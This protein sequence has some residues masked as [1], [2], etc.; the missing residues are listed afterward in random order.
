MVGSDGVARVVDFGVSMAAGRLMTTR[1]GQLKGKIPYMAPEQIGGR[2]VDRRTDTY[3]VGV[4]LWEALTGRRL[5]RADQ[6]V[7]IMNSVLNDVVEPPSTIATHVPKSLDAVVLRAVQRDPNQRFQSAQEMAI[8]L[9]KAI[10]PAA[11]RQVGQWVDRYAHDVLKRRTDLVSEIEGSS[12]P[13]TMQFRQFGMNPTREPAP[14]F[15]D[16]ITSTSGFGTPGSA[17]TDS[18]VPALAAP[19]TASGQ[20]VGTRAADAAADAAPSS[21]TKRRHV[22]VAIGLLI[23]LTC[24]LLVVAGLK[25]L[26]RSPLTTSHGSSSTAGAPAQSSTATRSAGDP[27]DSARPELSASAPSTPESSASQPS[28]QSSAAPTVRPLTSA[29]A[30]A[31]AQPVRPATP[32]ARG[33]A[34]NTGQ[35]NVYDPY[36]HQ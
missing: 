23:A 6:E 16:A 21:G 29:G 18:S 25:L 10:L 34:A 13:I 14:S 32:K 30:R 1:Q 2:L 11:P 36:A 20:W 35:G 3:A 33:P 12:G 19:P 8:A 5:F 22:G 7:G 24:T 28:A 17:H 15:S 31:H 9:E 4:V 26:R 27:I